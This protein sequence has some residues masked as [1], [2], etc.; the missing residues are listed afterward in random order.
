MTD[1]NERARD[2]DSDPMKIERAQAVAQALRQQVALAGHW[3]ALEYGCGTGLLSFALQPYL[4]EITLADSAPGMLE[5]LAA[6]IGRANI[7]NMHP[8]LLDLEVDTAFSAQFDL[9]FSLMTLHHIQQVE[10]VLDHF[11]RLLN[12]GGWLCT[13]D[14]DQ[15]D[16]SFHPAGF[17]GHRGF[18]R[19]ALAEMLERAGFVNLSFSTPY[20]ILKRSDQGQRAYPLF[21]AAGQKP[22]V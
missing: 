15:E 17:S 4:G 20:T 22:G 12:P 9:I 2:W 8:L 6:K 14:L 1:F 7:Q 13:A 5:V 11:Y 16:G 19:G 10:P 18:E 3:Q 21:L